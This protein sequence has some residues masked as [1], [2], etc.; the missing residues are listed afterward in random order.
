[1]STLG[2]ELSELLEKWRNYEAVSSNP[3]ECEDDA[4]AL[5]TEW[6]HTMCRHD[7]ENALKRYGL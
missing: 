7:L 5:G 2:S 4:F 3:G 6:G 1:M